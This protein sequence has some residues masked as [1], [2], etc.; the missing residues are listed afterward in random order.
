MS[1]GISP[2]SQSSFIIDWKYWALI[3]LFKK[4]IFDISESGMLPEDPMENPTASVEE[5]V[6]QPTPGYHEDEDI[7]GN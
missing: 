4:R 2:S 3:T 6:T 5:T 1:K 7:E